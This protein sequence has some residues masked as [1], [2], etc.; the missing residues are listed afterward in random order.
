MLDLLGKSQTFYGVLA[1]IL[2]LCIFK[3][4]NNF[5]NEI[6][7]HIEDYISKKIESLGV[8]ANYDEL[9]EKI[10]AK[11]EQET[12]TGKKEQ[13]GKLMV[14]VSKLQRDISIKNKVLPNKNY[15]EKME[16]IKDADEIVR[17]PLFTL[18]YC[19]A[20]FVV[21]EVLRS[22]LLS[23]QELFFTT[24]SFIT[25]Y[26]SL[27]WMMLWGNFVHRSICRRERTCSDT[28]FFNN[29]HHAVWLSLACVL[30]FMAVMVVVQTMRTNGVLMPRMMLWL[31]LLLPFIVLGVYFIFKKPKSPNGY[32][33]SM[34]MHFLFIISLSTIVAG[35]WL[36]VGASIP[37]LEEMLIDDETGELLKL[38]IFL[39]TITNGLLLPFFLPL[40]CS[41]L[42]YQFQAKRRIVKEEEEI[43]RQI[44]EIQNSLEDIA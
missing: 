20:V 23:Q 43:A 40:I 5:I 6:L 30:P 3:N 41:G 18:F 38:G 17:A 14:L 21:D 27:Y 44:K 26:S 42:I 37:R 31:S 32:Y 22:S 7:K 11:M 36:F 39:F 2:V 16:R 35:I 19:F 15:K 33:I 24:L 25:F 10:G 13:Y 34:L 29:K 9:S 4:S 28:M 12:D 8:K 1:T